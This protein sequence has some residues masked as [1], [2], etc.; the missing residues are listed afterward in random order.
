MI[1]QTILS[2][3]IPKEADKFVVAAPLGLRR[4]GMLLDFIQ[5]F[6]K[7]YLRELDKLG[8]LEELP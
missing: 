4:F 5:R 3:L 8:L 7:R 6:S 1:C 2:Y